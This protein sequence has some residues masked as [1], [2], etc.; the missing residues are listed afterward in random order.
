MRFQNETNARIGTTEIN[1]D[2]PYSIGIGLCLIPYSIGIGI[3]MITG[4]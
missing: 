2:V 3:C 4:E 1:T